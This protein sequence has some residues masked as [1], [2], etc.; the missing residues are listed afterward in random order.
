MLSA[1]QLYIAQTL[2]LQVFSLYDAK[3]A[4]IK[5]NY[6]TFKNFIQMDLQASGAIM[7]ALLNIW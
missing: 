2:T 3:Q 1:R 6:M 5:I 4:V 7:H